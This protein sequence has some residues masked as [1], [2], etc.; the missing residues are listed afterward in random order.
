MIFAIADRPILAS[1]TDYLHL[2]QQ[3][4]LIPEESSLLDLLLSIELDD[5]DLVYGNQPSNPTYELP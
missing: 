2:L 5:M 1:G 3:A 4:S